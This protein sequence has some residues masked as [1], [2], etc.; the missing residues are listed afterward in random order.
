MKK[1]LVAFLAVLICLL[2]TIGVWALE[3]PKAPTTEE[4]FYVLDTIGVLSD[5]TKET[6]L[7]ENRTLRSE[8][9]GE[10]VTVLVETMGDT[11]PSQYAA[12]IGSSWRV[13][14]REYGNGMVLLIVKDTKTAY[15]AFDNSLVEYKE[16][17]DKIANETI[18]PLLLEEKYDEAV[19]AGL[20]SLA[21]FLSESGIGGPVTHYSFLDFRKYEAGGMSG[22]GEQQTV[23]VFVIIFL[24]AAALFI[25]ALVLLST[26]G[27]YGYGYSCGFPF[28]P[29]LF[30][31]KHSKKNLFG[32]KKSFF[33]DKR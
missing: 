30:A 27:R 6:A 12:L 7:S 32:L 5:E 4:E 11:E 17:I 28:F 23:A 13:G 3:L 31:G 19:T 9:G 33:K 14:A 10:I 16:S 2:S 24:L 1:I 15:V 21:A 26:R 25:T 8:T 18:T 22:R 20:S 29:W